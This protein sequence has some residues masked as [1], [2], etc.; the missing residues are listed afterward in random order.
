VRSRDPANREVGIGRVHQ[1]HSS[2][3]VLP[4]VVRQGGTEALLAAIPAA[5]PETRLTILDLLVRMA[6]IGDAR[7]RMIAHDA[8][9][10]VAAGCSVPSMES[11]AGMINRCHALAASLQEALNIQKS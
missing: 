6:P 3:T 10:R 4:E 7:E 2:E 11:D 8:S 9:A 1:W 5:R